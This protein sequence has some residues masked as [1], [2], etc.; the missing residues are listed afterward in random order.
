[1]LP[2]APVSAANAVTPMHARA[3]SASA[4]S[5]FFQDSGAVLPAYPTTQAV[6]THDL[7][8]TAHQSPLRSIEIPPPTPSS[9]SE[10]FESRQLQ[11]N[12]AIV[13]RDLEI[14]QL[15]AELESV[16]Q[17]WQRERDELQAARDR[18]SETKRL[19]TDAAKVCFVCCL[20]IIAVSYLLCY[21]QTALRACVDALPD[22]SQGA[23]PFGADSPFF[24]AELAEQEEMVHR[25]GHNIKQVS[26]LFLIQLRC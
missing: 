25:M 24:R 23:L 5:V 7:F 2:Q 20:R 6:Q 3:T 12:N 22:I 26:E 14:S 21:H 11:L 1:M 19:T 8:P 16:R 10:D 4:L 13:Q 18:E 17:S 9:A 15:K